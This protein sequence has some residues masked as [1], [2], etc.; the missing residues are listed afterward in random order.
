MTEKT[1]IAIVGLGYVGL[2]LAVEFG[3]KFPVIGY[4][5]SSRKIEQYKS[6]IDMTKEIGDVELQKSNIEFTC[7]EKRLSEADFIIVAVPTPVDKNNN[8]NL[9]FLKNASQTVG[10][11]MRK[12]TVIVFEST[13]YPGATEEVCIPE[14]ES[15]SGFKCGVDFKV[16]YSPERINPGDRHHRLGNI[17][18]IISAIDQ[19]TLDTIEEIYRHVIREDVYRTSTIKVAEA[20]KVIENIQRDI[21]IALV[22]ELSMIFNLMN[23]DT[24][25]VLE[26]A[27]TKWN[28]IKFSPGLVGGHCIGVDPYY[29]TY[30]AQKYGYYPEVI[31]AGRRINNNVGKYIADNL[32][33]QLIKSECPVKNAKILILG[34]TYKENVR[35]IRNTKVIDI[36]KELEEY[37]VQIFVC[38]PVADNHEVEGEYGISLVDYSEVSDVDGILIAVGHDEYKKLTLDDLKFK[39]APGRNVLVDIKGIINC[40]EA[41]LSVL[42]YWKL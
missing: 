17:K 42:S 9:M 33:K 38:D 8:P 20:A 34:I 21:N 36:I 11:N 18:K 37:G 1:C 23:I 16:G 29:L 14:L 10:R 2:P 4:D 31:L 25:E 27:A 3:K 22:N 13:V 15:T 30:K 5:I 24:N 39:L 6:G 41:E 26:A 28:F 7:D 40:C 32:V 12:G 19:E 35:D